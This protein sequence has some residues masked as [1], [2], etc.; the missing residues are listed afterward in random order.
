MVG[1]I[2]ERTD[3]WMDGQTDGGMEDRNGIKGQWS[4]GRGRA[5]SE[6]DSNM[7]SELDSEAEGA[8][9]VSIPSIGN[10]DDPV[11]SFS[12]LRDSTLSTGDAPRKANFSLHGH[13]PATFPPS[14]ETPPPRDVGRAT[15]R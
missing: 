2:D 1:W 14:T 4:G 10:E 8:S 5:P 7:G 6:L 12:S 11:L 3:G 13:G 15:K 9:D